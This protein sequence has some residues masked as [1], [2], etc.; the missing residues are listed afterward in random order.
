MIY[1]VA[2]G[3]AD[4]SIPVVLRKA[5]DGTVLTGA[6]IAN[7]DLY[8]RR[9]GAAEAAKVDCTALTAITD[10]H[11]DNY[12]YEGGNGE[13]RIDWPDACFAAGAAWVRLTV[14]YA[15]AFTEHILVLL[16]SP[17]RFLAGT[18]LPAAAAD[19][20]GGLPISDAG[21]LDLDTLLARLDAAITT[22]STYAGADTAGTTTLL[23]RIIGTLDTG[24]HKPQSGDAYGYLGTNL[25]ALGANATEAGASADD[26]VT[27]LK[28]DAQW[29][30][31]LGAAKGKA[32]WDA[33]AK[34]WTVYA[35]DNTTPLFT[36]TLSASGRT[37][38]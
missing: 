32:V 24:T 36:L 27:A 19:A 38:S 23:S 22:R 30:A 28:A 14:V 3:S 20:A 34:T 12:G 10:A 2:T 5:A 6:T 16:V 35:T 11:S 9:A 1:P 15:T 7:I 37:V 33:T 8:Y 4:V 26:V 29:K 17:T 31:I 13:Y 18:A 25:G 21:G